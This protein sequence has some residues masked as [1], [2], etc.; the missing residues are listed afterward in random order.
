MLVGLGANLPSEIG[1]PAQTL[2]S[3]IE[4][5]PAEGLNLR[6]VSRFFRTP[7]FPDGTA[8][9]YVNVA[10]RIASDLSPDAVLAALH[11]IEHR[12]GRLRDRRW[13]MRTLDLDLLAVGQ[14]VLPD[15]CA[16]RQWHDLAPA[17]QAKAVPDRLIVP[18]PRLQ[19]RAFVLVPLA[20]IAPDWVHPVLGQSVAGLCAQ[21]PRADVDAVRPI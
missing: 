19:D 15:R 10:V 3:A 17:A 14:C 8:P 2:L 9:D 16:F 13:G 11:R 1:E 4:N 20:D 7:S 6:A 5:M 12:F 21:L 18:H